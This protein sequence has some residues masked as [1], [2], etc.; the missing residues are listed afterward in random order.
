MVSSDLTSD[1]HTYK[2]S[3]NSTDIIY[4]LDG[5]PIISI[6]KAKQAAAGKKSW[7]SQD[8]SVRMGPWANS[9]QWAGPVDWTT[10]PKGVMKVRNFKMTGCVAK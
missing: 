6:N 8:L 3:F 2:T 9:G 4:Y 1:F 10:T 5:K 7:L